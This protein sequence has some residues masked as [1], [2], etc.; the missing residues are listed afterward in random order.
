MNNKGVTLMELMIVIIVMG[1][2]AAFTTM[3]ISSIVENQKEKVDQ[4]NAE[5]LGDAISLA[6]LDGNII[7][8]NN[9]LW[10]TSTNRGYA[11]TGSWFYDDMAGY[12]SNR[13][14]P[15]AS[16]AENTYNASGGTYRFLFS[17]SGNQVTVYYYDPSKTRINLHTFTLEDY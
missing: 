14:V 12:I 17:V 1:I 15:Q 11:G 9:R 10:N 4:A 2:L 16:I 3:S 6:Y 8:Q 7:I 13:L 5:Y